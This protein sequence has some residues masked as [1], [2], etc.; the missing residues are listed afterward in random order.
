MGRSGNS[1]AIHINVSSGSGIG[2]WEVTF[3]D[4]HADRLGIVIQDA[5]LDRGQVTDSRN[6]KD[7][8]I[9]PARDQI[10]GYVVAIRMN[11]NHILHSGGFVIDIAGI[12]FTPES[13]RSA[14]ISAVEAK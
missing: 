11:R 4:E 5:P 7:I 2:L 1:E 13:R 9:C 12:D 10:L 8:R 3:I 14:A 6:R